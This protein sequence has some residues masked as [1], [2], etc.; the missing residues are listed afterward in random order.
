MATPPVFSAGAVLTAAQMNAVGLWLVKTD[1]ITGT[2]TTKTLSSVFSSDYDAYKVFALVRSSAAGGL[3]LALG[4]SSTN[5]SGWYGA[6][7]YW[8]ANSVDGVIRF[9][10]AGQAEISFTDTNVAAYGC[11]DIINPNKA[12]KT[13]LSG[14]G[15][16]R[17]NFSMTYSYVLNNT[18]S[19]TA[20]TLS[21]SGGGQLTSGN[22]YVYGY[23]V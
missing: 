4:S 13:Y 14:S 2:S 23:R 12:A 5:T 8:G 17:D 16:G 9:S 22:V 19:Y 15:I 11:F 1:T 3:R 7:P 10:N 6:E 21:C 18:T 20:F